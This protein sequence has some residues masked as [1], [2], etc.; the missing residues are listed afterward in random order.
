[1]K[2]RFM[3]G[4]AGLNTRAMA[5]PRR[6]SEKMTRQVLWKGD[7][8][9]VEREAGRIGGGAITSWLSAARYK[10]ATIIPLSLVTLS[11]QP[12]KVDKIA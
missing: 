5:A 7:S 11:K 12:I 4:R 8:S 3:R 1:M 2:S 9:R 10:P 6:F